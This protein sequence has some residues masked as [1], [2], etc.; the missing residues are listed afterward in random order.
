M[1]TATRCAVEPSSFISETMRT[2]PSRLTSTALS[3]GE[4]KLTGRGRVDEDVAR[5]D[6]AAAVFVEA[7]TVDRH[8]AG[9]G[10]HAA[11]GHLVERC[12]TT[13]FAA[14]PVERVVAKDLAGDPVACARGARCA[15]RGRARSRAPCARVARRARCRGSRSNP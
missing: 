3:S 15:R 13:E 5:R 4:S 12:G 9:D 14:Q 10:G 8:V 11:R 2:G 6:R 7:E 1:D